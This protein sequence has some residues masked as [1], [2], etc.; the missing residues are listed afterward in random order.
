MD[1]NKLQSFLEDIEAVYTKHGIR[2]VA[3]L[4]VEPIEKPSVLI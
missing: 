1:N 2:L 4:E 3:H